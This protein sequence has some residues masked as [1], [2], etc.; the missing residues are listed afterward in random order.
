MEGAGDSCRIEN[1][2]KKRFTEDFEKFTADLKNKLLRIY[3]SYWALKTFTE[4]R[5]IFT[6]E[7]KFLVTQDLVSL[8]RRPKTCSS[9]VF[10]F[11]IWHY[12]F[13]VLRKRSRTLRTA[14][15]TPCW[16]IR[17]WI[18]PKPIVRRGNEPIPVSLFWLYFGGALDILP[19][20]LTYYVLSNDLRYYISMHVLL[21]LHI[22]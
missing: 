15:M 3:D 18:L 17:H 20:Y 21:V 1:S 9:V 19:I 7:I 16:T 12:G 10:T 22:I 4:K 11:A 5:Y 8:Q 2:K 14:S 13:R 6:E